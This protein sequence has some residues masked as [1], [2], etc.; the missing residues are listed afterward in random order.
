MKLWLDDVRPAPDGWVHAKTTS[1]ACDVMLAGQVEEA[2]LDHDLGVCATCL[3]GRL[4]EFGDVVLDPP[5]RCLCDTRRCVCGCH[6]TGHD[7]V[8]WCAAQNRWPAS[9]P[10]V[11]SMNPVGAANMR[12]VIDRYWRAP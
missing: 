2:S 11:H 5:R 8:L 6:Q 10:H 4:D 3:P 1:E 7:F 9:K 12:A